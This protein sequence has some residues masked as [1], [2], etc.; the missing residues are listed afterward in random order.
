MSEHRNRGGAAGRRDAL[1][2]GVKVI[3]G[4]EKGVVEMPKEKKNVM[5]DDDASPAKEPRRSRKNTAWHI[6]C[7]VCGAYLER[8]FDKSSGMVDCRRCRSNLGVVVENATVLVFELDDPDSE[9][10]VER[11][12]RYQET[13]Q[14]LRRGE[15][16]EKYRLVTVYDSRTVT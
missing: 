5:A 16:K 12:S 2:C 8:I 4:A 10:A 1:L 13:L 15:L 6:H 11:L 3:E 9:E 7:P 14:R